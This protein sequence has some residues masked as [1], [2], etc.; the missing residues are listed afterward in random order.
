MHARSAGWSLKGGRAVA[1][2]AKRGVRIKDFALLVAT[3][4]GAASASGAQAAF[5]GRVLAST[6]GLVVEWP[7]VAGL[8]HDSDNGS[9]SGS[10]S[11]SS[12]G[13]DSDSSSDG[14]GDSYGGRGWWRRRRLTGGRWAVPSSGHGRKMGEG[15]LLGSRPSTTNAPAVAARRQL[16]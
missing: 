16:L 5:I 13:S 7:S 4:D 14:G 10:N 12:S 8:T 15:G 9:G 1:K 6:V 11:D 3:L 2:S